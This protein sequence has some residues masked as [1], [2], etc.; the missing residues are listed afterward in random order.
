MTLNADTIKDINYNLKEF[1]IE[2]LNIANG[3]D[4]NATHYCYITGGENYVYVVHS[5]RVP[6]DMTADWSY[7][8]VEQYDWNGNPIRKYKLKNFFG[9]VYVDEARKRMVGITFA[10]D[11]PFV[12]F[13]LPE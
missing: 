5:G 2:T 11:D 6:S 12:E 3:L 9:K 4:R 1:D 8:N 10:Y 7:I 13:K